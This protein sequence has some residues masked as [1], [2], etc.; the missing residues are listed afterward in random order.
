MDES[1][2][3][4]KA[5]KQ[6]WVCGF[7]RV[8]GA[9]PGVFFISYGSYYDVGMRRLAYLFFDSSNDWQQTVFK[10]GITG[11][12]IGAALAWNYLDS[13]KRIYK[14]VVTA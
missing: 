14:W 4:R 10:L 6:A 3:V 9:L 11:A 2:E 7:L 12:V 5:C 1:E 13:V 8:C